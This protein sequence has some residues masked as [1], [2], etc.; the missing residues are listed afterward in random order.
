MRKF[1]Y[2]ITTG[3]PK[4][5]VPSVI[6]S[7]IEGIVKLIPACIA[8]V[9]IQEIFI[10][11]KEERSIDIST[12]I[13]CGIVGIVWYIV[14]YFISNRAYD[15]TYNAAY[16]V[17]AVG[18]TKLANHLRTLSLGYLE[19]RDPGDLSTMMLSDY[20]QVETVIS[21]MVPQTVTSIVLP[22]M[23]FIGML[24]YD[25][26]MAVSLFITMPIVG[27]IIFGTKILQAKFSH[28]HIAAKVD[29]VSRIQ[30][31]LQGIQEIK[32]YGLGGS[33]F[34]R[35]QDAFQ[36]L[37]KESLKLEVVIGP[38]VLSAISLMRMGLTIVTFMGTYYILDGSLNEITFLAFLLVGTRIY[39]PLQVVLMNYAEMRYSVI[40][41]ERIMDIR[42]QPSVKGTEIINDYTIR[43]DNVNFAYKDTEVLKNINLEI[44]PKSLTA[45]VGPSGSGK[46]TIVKLISRFYDVNK[47]QICFGNTNLNT[48]KPEDLYSHISMV[49][50]D[51]YLFKDT[52]I[53][54]LRVG[55]ASATHEEIIEAA[56]KANCHDFIMA[57]P[58]GYETMIG[59]GGSTL[60]GG[61][62]QRI[63][64][65]RA[66]LKDA[67]IVLLDEATASLDLENEALVQ[68]AINALVADKTVIMIAHRLKTVM[69]ADQI[70]VLENGSIVQNGRHEELMKQEGIYKQLFDLQ[71]QAQNW[72]IA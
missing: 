42:D 27:I 68:E 53:N 57:M 23:A 5:L 43:F 28:K 70:V 30:E 45:L 18:R 2:N 50:Q 66:L 35:L 71:R 20:T 41:A 7:I 69:H 61:E 47:G 31:Y 39:D 14:Q 56:K 65:A 46:T 24:F 72:V 26:R 58:E 3:N 55:N 54:N 32:A 38:I 36:R 10:A 25:W 8:F 16:D 59:E 12:F 9:S 13:V 44:Q 48:I 34:S 52:I 33:K 4:Q 37:K 49:F 67:E 15:L 60:S 21:H 17:S 6:Y 11:L 64:I 19:S 63:S 40:S 29:S 22:V 62:K 1:F 51:V